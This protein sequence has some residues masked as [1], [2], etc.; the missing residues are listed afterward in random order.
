MGSSGRQID[1]LGLLSFGDGSDGEVTI[2]VNTTITRDMFYS[3][4]TVNDTFNLT[5]GGFKIFCSGTVTNNEGI[6]FTGNGAGS[7]S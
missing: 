5:G 6:V 4:L 7:G 1:Q 2:S 3:S